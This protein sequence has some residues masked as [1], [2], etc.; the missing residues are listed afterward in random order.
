[1]CNHSWPRK[2]GFKELPEW[3]FGATEILNQTFVSRAI[4]L[5]PSSSCLPFME[6]YLLYY[7]DSSLFTEVEENLSGWTTSH[8]LLPFSHSINDFLAQPEN[9]YSGFI[10]ILFLFF[11]KYCFFL[12]SHFSLPLND[13]H[14]RK[15]PTGIA[16]SVDMQE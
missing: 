7:M 10:T 5:H 4:D 9:I 12:F 2:W 14:V 11:S 3:A 8:A 13:L 1:M 16:S 6:T 15:K